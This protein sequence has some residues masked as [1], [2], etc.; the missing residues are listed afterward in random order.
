MKRLAALRMVLDG[1][2]PE[3]AYVLR[4]RVPRRKQRIQIVVDAMHNA[5]FAVTEAHSSERNDS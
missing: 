5:V 4:E 3:G 1:A 2:G